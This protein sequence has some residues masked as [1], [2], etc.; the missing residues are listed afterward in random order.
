M[1]ER[2][3]NAAKHISKSLAGIE[4]SLMFRN[5]RRNRIFD[6]HHQRLPIR[7][8]SNFGYEWVCFVTLFLVS[9][10]HFRFLVSCC[11]WG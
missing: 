7:F 3:R 9:C 4:T 1:P 2:V 10:D 5:C 11:P 6:Q 8:S